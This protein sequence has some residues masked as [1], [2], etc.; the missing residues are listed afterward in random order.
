MFRW[1]INLMI[2]SLIFFPDKTFYE[3]PQD[4]GFEFEEVSLQTSDGVQLH[5]WYLK[6]QDEKGVILFLHGNAGNISGRL[7]KAKGWIER[8]ISVLLLD[9]R[10]YGKS[11][12]KIQHEKDLVID[13]QTGFKWL[14]ET[15]KWDTSKIILYG[16]SLGSN[17][18]IHL[19]IQYKATTLI[20][21]APYTSFVDL[22]KLHYSTFP[23]IMTDVLL[24]DFQ[25][26]NIDFIHKIQTPLF[27]FHGTR[28]E[29]CPYEMGKEL[30]EKAPEP[31]YFFSISDGT[32]NDLPTLAGED[33]W[34]KP[35]KFVQQYLHTN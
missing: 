24:R 34:E 7:H 29:T 2:A 14:E 25:F 20:L 8:G 11:T 19:A 31:K 32:H 28:D 23:G 3:Q 27:I 4:Y 10:S 30:Y 18:A 15:K 13:A 5:S 6:A 9:Y 26:S 22:G 33:Y 16:E 35:W 17:P 21:E 12:G 1:L